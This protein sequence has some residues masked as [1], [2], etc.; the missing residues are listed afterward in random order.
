MSFFFNLSADILLTP[1]KFARIQNYQ[2][3]DLWPSN[4]NELAKSIAK[5]IGSELF[6]PYGL[7][8]ICELTA[9]QCRLISLDGEQNIPFIGSYPFLCHFL[10]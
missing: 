4:Y 6:D 9:T 3:G 5:S 10:S 2:Y 8:E 7:E 1:R